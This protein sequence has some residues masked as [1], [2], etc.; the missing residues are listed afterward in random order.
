MNRRD[1][2]LAIISLCVAPLAGAQPAARSARIGW[3]APASSTDSTN[4]EDE[5]RRGLRDLGWVEGR[6]IVTES[7]YADRKIERLPALASELVNRRV[8]VIVAVTFASARAAKNASG[9]VPIV[10]V[11]VGDPVGSGLIASLARP[12]GNITGRSFDVT[13]EMNA[14]LLELLKRLV[15]NLSRVAVLWN[16]ASPFHFSYIKAIQGAAQASGI[17]LQSLTVQKPD[18]L[19]SAFADMVRERAGGLVVFTDAFM[20]AHRAQIVNLAARARLPVIYGNS[21][22]PESG[23]LMSYG[24]SF[25][26]IWRGAATYVDKILKGA[27]PAD[28]PVEQPTTFELV[29]NMKTA[30]AMGLTIPQSVLLQATRVIE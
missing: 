21:L 25:A 3:L 27:K 7:R 17:R 13:P 23:G 20:S 22:F 8:D 10:M 1:T 4:L 15:P 11:A 28:I 16:S 12:G 5:F 6:N 18:E 19:E 29:V 2:F 30:K 9:T 26:E 14:K 24:A